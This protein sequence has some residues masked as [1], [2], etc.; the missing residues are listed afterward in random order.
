MLGIPT[1][2]TDRNT[3]LVIM[4]GELNM[5]N[6]FISPIKTLLKV[7]ATVNGVKTQAHL[8]V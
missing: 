5:P 2:A 7:K 3:V 8:N 1:V 4:E 6:V